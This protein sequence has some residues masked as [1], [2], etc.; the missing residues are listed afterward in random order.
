MPTFT[1]DNETFGPTCRV[2]GALTEVFRRRSEALRSATYSVAAIGADAAEV[3]DGHARGAT[4][5]DSPLGRLAA[6]GGLVLLLGVGHTANTSVHVGEFAAGAPYLDIRSTPTGQRT[7]PIGFQ[8]AAERS[9]RSSPLRERGAIR[10]GRVGAALAQLVP[11]ASRRR[12]R[13]SPPIPRRLLDAAATAARAPGRGSTRAARAR[14]TGAGRARSAPR[15]G[16]AAPAAQPRARD[17]VVHPP[18]PRGLCGRRDREVRAEEELERA[19]RSRAAG[20]RRSSRAVEEGR[21]V[22][23]DVRVLPDSRSSPVATDGPGGL[24]GLRRSGSRSHQ[25]GVRGGAGRPGRA[26]RPG[27]EQAA[28]AARRPRRRGAPPPERVED[29]IVRAELDPFFSSSLARSSSS[30]APSTSGWIGESRCGVTSSARRGSR[31][32]DRRASGCGR[33]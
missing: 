32:I 14:A 6:A 10:D 31:S 27:E 7:A 29:L 33:S 1:Y 24:G 2:A 21:D 17:R 12:S 9:A 28:R 23:V 5:V 18:A 4:G 3:L 11:G 15:S 26:R 16:R 20:P 8:A 25:E 30:R 13:S 22:G 19:P